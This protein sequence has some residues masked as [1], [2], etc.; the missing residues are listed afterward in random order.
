MRKAREEKPLGMAG[1]VDSP[2]DDL[3]QVCPMTC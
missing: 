3:A 2:H 1:D